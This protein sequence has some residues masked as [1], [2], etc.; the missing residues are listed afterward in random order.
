[1]T[2]SF[3]HRI[4]IL[5]VT[6]ALL[7]C[8]SSSCPP[9]RYA[10]YSLDAAEHPESIDCFYACLE[11][12]GE[13]ARQACFTLCE[14]VVATTTQTPCS[15]ETPALCRGYVIAESMTCDED[16]GEDASGFFDF[17]VAAIE[18]AESDDDDDS[19]DATSPGDDRLDKKAPRRSASPSKSKEWTNS[20][21]TVTVPPSSFGSKAKK[22]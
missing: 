13:K 11:K 7:A 6:G 22:R 9:P 15:E 17:V 19:D 5:V 10:Q 3:V 21:R 20:S 4:A 1:M 18:A 8:A 12:K 2:A 16:D 14:G